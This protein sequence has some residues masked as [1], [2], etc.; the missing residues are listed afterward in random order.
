MKVVN[1]IAEAL[2][3]AGISGC[4]VAYLAYHDTLEPDP[5]L[6]PL[7]NVHFEWAPRER[8]YSHALDDDTCAVNPGYYASL[9]R[10]I[11]LFHGRG[12]IFEYY[13]D[14]I[15]FGG[16][17]VAT[18]SVIARDLRAY[19]ALGL[20]SISCLTFGAYSTLAY[21]VNL[22]AF[23]R[24]TRSLNFDGSEMLAATAD[25][26]HPQCA[27]AMAGA[28]RAIA[29]ASAAILENGG[30]IMRPKAGRGVAA[31]ASDRHATMAAQLERACAAAAA[32]AGSDPVGRGQA[33]L[34]RYNRTAVTGIMAYLAALGENGARRLK[35]GEA[36]ITQI[37]E[38]IGLIHEI[39]ADLRGTWGSYDIEW[40]R[41][42]WIE[43]MRRRLTAET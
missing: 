30:D 18:P 41:P 35:D 14:A 25:Q 20:T 22:E 42:I 2:A 16:L 38:A 28:Y 36:A 9:R 27:P 12:H 10:Y 40:I 17:G 4:P 23:T 34:W 15:L 5:G 26:L 33:G 29:K 32:I 8:C 31:L 43:A 6:R 24:G 39:Q 37:G 11:E 7:A 19:H 13:A 21:P 1:A 3:L